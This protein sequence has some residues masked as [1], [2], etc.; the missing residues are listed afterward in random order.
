MR[1]AWFRSHG[2]LWSFCEVAS[3]KGWM[4]HGVVTS[5][6]ALNTWQDQ[7]LRSSQEWRSFHGLRSVLRADIGDAMDVRVIDGGLEW[8]ILWCEDT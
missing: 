2:K 4:L 8:L 6:L 1:S 3:G 7:Q 5:G